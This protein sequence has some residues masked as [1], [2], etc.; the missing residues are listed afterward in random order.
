M[1]AGLGITKSGRTSTLL[2]KHSFSGF[3]NLLSERD[4]T[5]EK[6]IKFRMNDDLILKTKFNEFVT[7]NT[8]TQDGMCLTN[9]PRP[10]RIVRKGA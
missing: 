9:C 6:L 8:V 1:I 3:E 4:R 10:Q 7:H 5:P 2:D